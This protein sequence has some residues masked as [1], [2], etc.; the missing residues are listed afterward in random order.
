MPRIL[1]G[2]CAVVVAFACGGAP[3]LAAA[4]LSLL[5][6]LAGQ[7]V[8]RAYAMARPNARSSHREP[9]PQ[10]G[11]APVILGALCTALGVT[12]VGDFALTPWLMAVAA[13]ALLLAATGALDDIRPMPVG[14]RLTAQLAAVALIVFLA[15][16]DWR[17]FGS[18]FPWLAERLLFV[19]AGVWFV[20]L[21]NFMDGID[22]MTLAGFLPLA[23]IAVLLPTEAI[24]PT[25]RLLAGV[26][27]GGLAGFVLL[28]WHPARL[29]LGDVGSLPIGALGGAILFDVAAH[30]AVA[31]AIILPLYHFI[32]ATTTLLLRAR[33]SE[34]V[35]EAHRQHAY[36]RA[37]DGGWSQ[38]RVSGGVL[39]LNIALG[40]LALWSVGRSGVVQMTCVAIALCAVA[41]LIVVFRRPKVPA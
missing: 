2:A 11:G 23:A 17:V 5:L 33:R 7:P 41:G 18:A 35:W 30:G 13:S 16:S 24:S 32:D 34:R 26:F 28:N 8:F 29:F 21:T 14:P 38:P 31:A 10:G 36:Q 27:L 15:P 22:G 9:V 25:G 6:C 3:A 19:I 12:L 40:L 4:V 39:V 20:N 37:V 1:A